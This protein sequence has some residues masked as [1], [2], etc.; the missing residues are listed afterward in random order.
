MW[1]GGATGQHSDPAPTGTEG[2]E[3]PACRHWPTPTEGQES[4]PWP[5]GRHR[6]LPQTSGRSSHHCK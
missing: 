1:V 4:Q 3:R 5:P 2:G 6:E